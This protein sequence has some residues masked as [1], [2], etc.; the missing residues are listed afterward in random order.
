MAIMIPKETKL[1]FNDSLGEQRVYEALVALPDN[2]IIFHSV[3]WNKKYVNGKVQW[4]ESDFVI[5]NPERGLLVVE[6]KSGGISCKDGKWFQT[7]IKTSITH[8]LQ[9]SPLLQADFGK[10]TFLDLF[11]ESSNQYVRDCKINS[12]VWFPSIRS[13]DTVGDMPNEYKPEIVFTQADFDNVGDSLAKAFD[14]YQMKSTQHSVTKADISDVINIMSPNFNV[15]PNLSSE[16]N[17]QDYVF[18]K[19]TDEQCRLLDYLEEQEEAAIQGGGGTGKTVL[20]IEKA[21]RL[22][23]EDKV[24]FLCFNRMLLDYLKETYASFMPNVYFFNLHSLFR[25][26]CGD[27]DEITDDNITNYLNNYDK[28]EWPYKHIIIDESQDFSDEH[29]SLLND[30]SKLSNG[31]FYIFYD[32][33]QLVQRFDYNSW[34][35]KVNCRLVLTRNCRNTLSIASTSFASIGINKIKMNQD[36]VGDKPTLFFAKDKASTIDFIA[37]AIKYYKEQGFTK[38][39]I[40]ILTLKTEKKSIL[41]PETSIGGYRI[42]NDRKDG[43]ILFTTARKFKGLESSIVIMVD[44][45][46][47]CFMNEGNRNLFYV[48]ASRAKHI[49][50]I[51][52]SA[53]DNKIDSLSFNLFGEHKKNP[54]LAISS[55]LL[56]K[57][58]D[59]SYYK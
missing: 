15:F 7:N 37:N 46:E 34:I 43:E 38:K 2:Y 3:R 47:E 17:D 55:S 23:S 36:I 49:L 1:D 18:K 5:F 44:F 42:S 24:L 8:Q 20:A 13:R 41:Y 19:L 4:G 51:V 27:I 54:K 58:V 48:A 16:A 30:I 26:N 50:S 9:K 28:Y 45:D 40:V 11:S 53:D 21:R 39:Q 10:Y 59:N 6:V 12:I 31:S 56:V 33:N 14:F 22:S 35:D 29:L 57:I 52:G 25:K 32:K